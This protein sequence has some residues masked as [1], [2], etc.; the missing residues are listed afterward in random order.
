MGVEKKYLKRAVRS[1][2]KRFLSDFMFEL[3]KEEFDK[4][5]EQDSCLSHSRN[6]VL[7]MLSS[8]L[9]SET[10]IEVNIEIMQAFVAVR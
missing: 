4:R 1:N 10:T 5:E 2:I 9:N 3:T 6:E 8:V 7:A